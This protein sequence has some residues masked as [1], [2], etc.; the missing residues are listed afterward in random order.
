[1]YKTGINPIT[2]EHLNVENA[3]DEFLIDSRTGK[4]IPQNMVAT[5]KPTQTEL[6]RADFAKSVL[7]SLDKLV[8]L[9]KAGKLPNGPVSGLS[10]QALAK[11][12]VGKA[13]AQEALNYISLV[14]SAATGAHVGGRFSLPVLNKMQGLIGINMGT[15]QFGGAVASI[16]DVMGQYVNQGGR[17][18]VGE[19]K[20]LSPED[21]GRLTSSTPAS[22]SPKPPSNSNIVNDLI[23]KHAGGQ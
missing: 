17:M 1:M 9:Q 22:G 5:L 15:D 2:K 6:N 14:Q 4:P 12:G 10:A 11:A 19:Y 13:D 23:R 3:P 21:R 20:Q 8:E 7:H 16:R 18:T